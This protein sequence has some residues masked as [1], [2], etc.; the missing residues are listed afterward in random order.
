MPTAFVTGVSGQDGT[1]LVERLLSEDWVVHGLVHADDAAAAALSARFPALVLH[2]GDIRDT[3]AIEAIVSS[4]EPDEFYNLAGV[5]SV[6]QSWV[7]PVMTA[8][9]TGLAV[10]GILDCLWRLS[11]QGRKPVRFLQASSAEI[12]GDAP[13]PQDEQTPLRPRTPYGAAKAYAHHLVAVYRARGLHAVGAILYNHESPLRAPTFVTRK[14]TSTVAA[15]A[16]GRANELVLGDVAVRRDWGWAPDYVDA[17]IRAVRHPDPDDYVVATGRV[18]S[19][20]DF[21][22]AAFEHVGIAGWEDYLRIDTALLRPADPGV[23]VGSAAKA[24]EVLGWRPRVEFRE[25]VA[26]MVD[27]DLRRLDRALR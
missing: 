11:T 9:V 17:M 12:F 3:S 2:S 8:E 19:V 10:A 13:A 16:R 22:A 20:R 24:Q 23:L 5:T 4:V 15:I 7:K 18:H 14:I 26:R 6:A 21:A 27:D 25:V 1:Y